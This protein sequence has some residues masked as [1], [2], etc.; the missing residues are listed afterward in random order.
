MDEHKLRVLL[1]VAG[2]GSPLHVFTSTGST[3]DICVELA[4]GGAPHGTLVVADEQRA[5]RGRGERRWITSP[6]SALAMSVLLRP[7]LI[8]T[9]LPGYYTLLGSLAVVEAL[10]QLGASSWIKWPNDVVVESG[11]LAGLLAE[12]SWLGE[13]LDFVV[14]GI[15]V[16]VTQD[17]VPPPAE[18]D[19]P[20]ACVEAAVGKNVGR[21]VL[22]ASILRQLAAGLD[23]SDPHSLLASL[24]THLAYREQELEIENDGRS[25]RG[26]IDGL[27]ENGALRI[28]F[29]GGEVKQLDLTAHIRPV[30]LRIV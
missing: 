3:N 16:N 9:L 15:G 13:V 14:L 7:V 28:V 21:E 12:A 24:E 23:Q 8:G 11:K 10:D 4:R 22:A 5:G 6:G 25:F 19:F 1:P 20:A 26:K 17:S 29:A 2:L 18:I 27:Q 30:D